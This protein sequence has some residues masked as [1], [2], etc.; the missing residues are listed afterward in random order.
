MNYWS[1]RY[2]HSCSSLHP[3]CLLILLY[4]N[5]HLSKRSRNSAFLISLN[6]IFA[7]F[8]A[9]YFYFIWIFKKFYT[10]THTHTHIYPQTY[11]FIWL[12]RVLVAAGGLLSCGMWTLSC[13]MHVG[14]SSLTRDRTRAACIG[15]TESY[16]LCHQ[17]SPYFYFIYQLFISPTRWQTPWSTF[18]FAMLIHID[19]TA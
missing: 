5:I 4:I 15:S 2:P 8:R 17:G 11:L 10:H 14:S 16:P 13:G 9:H 12:H 7:S 19:V 1:P 18:S 3:K 6:F